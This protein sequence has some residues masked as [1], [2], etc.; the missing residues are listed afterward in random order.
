MTVSILFKPRH[1]GPIRIILLPLPTLG[2][3]NV[4]RSAGSATSFL[5]NL[6]GAVFMRRA[7]TRAHAIVEAD[8]PRDGASQVSRST[9]GLRVL[10]LRGA[11][12]P[13]QRIA[14]IPLSA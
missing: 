11:L 4:L 7:A 8:A 9:L 13:G 14:E 2:D 1:P 12:R 6:L 3:N 10:L 5:Q